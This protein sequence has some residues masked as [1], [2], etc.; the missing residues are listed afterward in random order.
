MNDKFIVKTVE[1]LEEFIN[2]H[3]DC[4]V[5]GT[6]EL[7]DKLN[8]NMSTSLERPP[9]DFDLFFKIYKLLDI[10]CEKGIRYEVVNENERV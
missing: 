7:D 4:K 10:M 9:E 8:R 2:T 1:E 5:Y 3:S 6:K